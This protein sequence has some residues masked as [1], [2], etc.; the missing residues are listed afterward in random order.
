MI[1]DERIDFFTPNYCEIVEFVYFYVSGTLLFYFIFNFNL[2][3]NKL[4]NLYFYNLS[5]K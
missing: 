4:Q 2:I 5:I 3:D 1:N